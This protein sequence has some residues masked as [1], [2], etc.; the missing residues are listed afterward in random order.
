MALTLPSS[1]NTLDLGGDGEVVIS[2]VGPSAADVPEP[3]S[4][5]LLATGLLALSFVAR[6][7][8]PE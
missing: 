8:K 7:K 2:Y 5:A 1:L 6:R 4:L 3:G